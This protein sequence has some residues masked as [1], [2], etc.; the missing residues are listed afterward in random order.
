M[1]TLL[2]VR[3]NHE[4]FIQL[5]S[6]HYTQVRPAKVQFIQAFLDFLHL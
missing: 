4:L 5:P 1:L 3:Y 2:A 6:F